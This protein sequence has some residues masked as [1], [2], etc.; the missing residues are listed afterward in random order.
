VVPTT[1]LKLGFPPF[2]YWEREWSEEDA[3]S[4]LS[5]IKLSKVALREVIQAA[6]KRR[7]NALANGDDELAERCEVTIKAAEHLLKRSDSSRRE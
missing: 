7:A 2:V 1:R 3:E 6:K 5:Q 4:R